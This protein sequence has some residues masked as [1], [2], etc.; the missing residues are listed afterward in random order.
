M[1]RLQ[2][3][4]SFTKGGSCGD[5]IQYDRIIMMGSL[6]EGGKI[7]GES[8][9]GANDVDAGNNCGE[10]SLL[11]EGGE[12]IMRSVRGSSLTSVV[13]V[14]NHGGWACLYR[15]ICSGEHRD[16]CTEESSQWAGG[17]CTGEHLESLGGQRVLRGLGCG[18][19]FVL[20]G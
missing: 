15:W 6:T 16:V 17:I 7:I 11:M 12:K 9:W 18:D 20:K 8:T 14:L 19:V 13:R 4:Q 5:N 2:W 10:H 1:S 3:G